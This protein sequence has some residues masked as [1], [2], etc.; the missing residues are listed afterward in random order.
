MVLLQNCTDLVGAVPGLSS[1]TCLTPNDDEVIDVKVEVSDVEE[2]EDPLL[3]S[4]AGMADDEVSCLSVQLFSCLTLCLYICLS[5]HPSINPSTYLPTYVHI[6]LSFYLSVY[7]SVHQS[8][9][10]TIHPSVCIY[11]SSHPSTHLTVKFMEIKLKNLLR[12]IGMTT[13]KTV[14]NHK[15]KSSAGQ[16]SSIMEQWK[17]S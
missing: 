13:L 12:R 5:S 17:C 10:P 3:I 9:L 2:E 1:D 8:I 14:M 7:V 6:C 16:A 15:E 4:S 11:L